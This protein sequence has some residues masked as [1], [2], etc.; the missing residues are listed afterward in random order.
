M[1]ECAPHARHR[2]NTIQ[3]TLGVTY[4]TLTLLPNSIF[5]CTMAV[6]SEQKGSHSAI[7]NSIITLIDVDIGA[8]ELC[9]GL[10]ASYALHKLVRL[11]PNLVLYLGVSRQ[12]SLR[13]VVGPQEMLVILVPASPPQHAPRTRPSI[14]PFYYVHKR[15]HVHK[16]RGENARAQP[17]GIAETRPVQTDCSDG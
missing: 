11:V 14:D 8:I 5:I 3:L 16:C 15:H 1:C 17:S 13:F 9:S 4:K 12:I 10:S 7:D 6:L 2:L